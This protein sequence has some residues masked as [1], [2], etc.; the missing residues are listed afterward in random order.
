M[1]TRPHKLVAIPL[2]VLIAAISGLVSPLGVE[3]QNQ[4]QVQVQL[5]SISSLQQA[6]TDARGTLRVFAGKSLVLN[7]PENLKR[8]SVT[9]PAIASAIIISPNQVLIH[10]LVP[11]S[12]TLLLWDEQERM[13]SFDLRVEIDVTALRETLQQVFPKESIQVTQSGSSLVLT[14]NVSSKDVLDRAAALAQTQA[15]TVVNALGTAEDNSQILLQVRFAEV[16]RTA[17]QQAGIN[18]FSTGG[19]NTFGSTTTG[20][21]GPPT[22]SSVG[23]V[24]G[25]V[26]RGRDPQAPNLVSGSIGNEKKDL[27][28]VFGLSDLLNIFVFRPDLNLGLTIKALEQRNLLQILAEPNLLA[29]NGR[30]AS[31][32]AGGEF[33]FPVVQTGAFQTVTIIFKEFGVRLKFVPKI[34]EDGSIRLKV[35][36]EVSSL[37]FTNALQISGFLIPALST[38]RAETEIELRDGQSF[39]IAGLIDNRLT[40]AASKVPV[41]GDIPIIGKFFRSRST[42]RSNTELLV[43]VTPK[44][45]RPLAPGQVAPAPTFPK[46]FLDKE[47]FDGKTGEAPPEKKPKNP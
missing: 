6:A 10:G 2:T 3:A 5:A 30:E 7:S 34:A 28:A 29:L 27:P 24:S 13:R 31:F 19:A 43:L 41:L 8:V 32:L 39:A 42:N 37:D 25:S 23:A 22:G 11:G 45:V 18:I 12:I 20:Q 44:L 33:P 14:G 16:D 38:R 9:D 15:K 26:Q 21:F 40:E 46:P 17:I 4:Q 47:K 1:N 35:A 36:P